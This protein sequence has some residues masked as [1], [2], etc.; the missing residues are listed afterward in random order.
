MIWLPNTT[1]Q[2]GWKMTIW[3]GPTTT[4]W[5]GLKMMIWNGHEVRFTMKRWRKVQGDER[6]VIQ[7]ENE[8]PH[9]IICIDDDGLKRIVPQS[10]LEDFFPPVVVEDSHNGE[11]KDLRPEIYG[12]SPRAL[13]SRGHYWVLKNIWVRRR[14]GLAVH[15]R[16]RTK[17]IL[18]SYNF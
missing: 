16:K 8:Q 14:I 6:I 15:Q 7:Y 13:K 5:H 10:P 18:C 17:I 12:S 1:I 9:N 11:D 3:H 4:I 2:H